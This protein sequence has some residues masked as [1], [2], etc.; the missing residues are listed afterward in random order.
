MLVHFIRLK[1]LRLSLTLDLIY[2]DD[3]SILDSWDMNGPANQPANPLHINQASTLGGH[4]AVNHQHHLIH[5]GES[6]EMTST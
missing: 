4:E 3:W 6:G 5:L 1:R 2:G